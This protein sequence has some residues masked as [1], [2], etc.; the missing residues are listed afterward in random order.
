MSDIDKKIKPSGQVNVN[1]S[2]RGVVHIGDSFEGIS[3]VRKSLSGA[4]SLSPKSV[5]SSDTTTQVCSGAS[6]LKPDITPPKKN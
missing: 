3:N 6:G 1:E 5:A 2:L 4:G